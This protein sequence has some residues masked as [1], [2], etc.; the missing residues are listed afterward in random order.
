MTDIVHESAAPKR[1]AV[2]A[3]YALAVLVIVYTINFIDRQILS[4]LAEGI[5]ADLKLDDA[6]LGFLYG[7]AFA[8]FYAV[9]GIPLG[10]LADRWY[11]GKLMALGLAV[12]SGMTAISG[13]SST[14]TQLAIARIGVGVGEASASPAAL[15]M[16][17]DYFPKHRRGLAMALYSSGVYLGM[18]LSLPI[19]GTISNSWDAAYAGG[20][21]P[22]GLRGWQAAFLAVGLPGLLVALW[23]FSLREPKRGGES[24][25]LPA[26]EAGVWRSFFADVGT[27]LPPF[28][29][30]SVARYPGALVR[31][32]TG[33]ALI[34]VA[35]ALMIALTGDI[36]QWVAY[37]TGVYALFSWT[38]SLRFTDP[39]TY[40]LIFGSWTV[41]L[42]MLGFGALAVITYGFGFWSAPY[43]IRTFGVTAS[44]AGASI[45]FPGAIAAAVGVILGGRV[46]DMWKA[47]HPA[48]RIYT[49]MMASVFTIPSLTFMFLA[50]DF[51]TYVIFSP[52]VYM[53]G[54]MWVGSAI[55]TY[56]DLVL[57][58]M[59][60]TIGAI[61]LVGSTMIGLALGPYGSGKIAAVTGSL[62]TGVFSLLT[63]S[64]SAL[65]A[66][67]F[68]SRRAPQAEASKVQRARDAGEPQRA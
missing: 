19:G 39:P 33:L 16:L 59:Y 26:A 1:M 53:A 28:T 9:F 14:Y 31:N 17:A 8:I 34:A 52:F 18:G 62:Q 38:Q 67:Y 25:D 64:V 66:L 15:S 21:A 4:I 44:V 37:G 24:G 12:W 45:G 55:A 65:V 61:Y 60:G 20:D 40:E 48:G 49:C 56:Q 54:N 10:R 32:L 41:P 50:P 11:R 29:L 47:R 13:F 6:Q 23:V 46:S 43:A 27:I 30:W 58:R 7:T 63:A 22:L 3:W 36:V 35:V 5:K 68:L 42:G 2:Y 57:P 51:R